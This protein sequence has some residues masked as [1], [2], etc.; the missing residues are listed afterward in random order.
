[1][2]DA[3]VQLPADGAGK[4]LDAETLTVGAN[5]VY[6]E[7][8]QISGDSATDIAPVTAADGLLVDL[9]LNNDVT[10]TGSVAVTNAGL[11]EL[12]AAID[13][14]LQVDVVGALPTGTNSIGQVTANAG[15]NLN[16]SALA[17]EAGNLATAVASLSVLDDWDESDRAKVNLIAGQVGVQG[18]AG[19]V[20]ALTQRVVVAT[21]QTAIP[22]SGT[23]TITGAATEAKQDTQ[24]T[25]LATIAGDTTDIETAVEL[26]DDTVAVLGTDTYTEATTKGLI[27]GAIRRDADTTLVNTT[28]EVSPL[29]VDANGRLKVEAFSGETLPVSLSS[30]TITGTV[31]VT[32]SGTWDEIGINDSGNSITVDG[33]VAVTGVSTEAKQDTQ[34]THLATIA[35]DTTDIETAVELIDDTVATL[36]TSTYTEATTKGLI[37][38]AVRRDADTTLVDTTNELSPLHVDANGRLKVEAFSGETLPVSGTVTANLAAGTNN[39]GDV[40]I[41]SIAAGDNNIGN[42]DVVSLPALVAGTANIGDVDVLTMPVTEIVGDVA[43]D[44]AVPSNPVIIGGRASTAQPTAVSADGDS[45]NLWTNRK[46]SPIV[47][48]APHVGLFG[49]PWTLTSVTAQYTTTQTSAVLLAGGASERIVVTKIGI[50]AG[51]TTAATVQVYFGTGAYSRGTSL[52]IFDGEFAPSATLKPGIRDTGPFISATNGDDVLVTTS[53]GITLTVTLWYYVIV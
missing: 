18:G 50:Q 1:M 43:A 15:T 12:A 53:A 35:G 9:G 40:D 41:L 3:V 26:I 13:T 22:V 52:A 16:T 48:A 10:V 42:V 47:S 33:T 2:A 32:Q 31:A 21:D 38:A 24:I 4:K 17:L 19:A 27:V 14:E 6:R 8:I 45:V 36:G 30:T 7:R 39:I 11:T 34:I 49:D 25:H 28:N 46:G 5:T 51:A 23:V 20:S 29:Q 37:V 44:A